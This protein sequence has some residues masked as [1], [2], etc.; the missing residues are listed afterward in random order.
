MIIFYV[1]FCYDRYNFMFN[2]S[3][4][5]MHAIH[6]ACLAARLSFCDPEELYRF[7]RYLN[8]MHAS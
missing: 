7:W 3:Q 1:G 4:N 8:M 2:E 5:I 6:N